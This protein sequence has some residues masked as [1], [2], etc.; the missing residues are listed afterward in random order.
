MIA[1]CGFLENDLRQFSREEGVTL[2]DSMETLGVDLR[3]RVKWFGAKENA[4]EDVQSEILAH[5]E[6][7]SLPKELHESGGQEVATCGYDA[8]KG[9]GNPSSGDVSHGEVKIEETGG[10]CCWHKED[11]LPVSVHGSVRHWSRGGAF[12]CNHSVLGRRSWDWKMAAR[13]KRSVDVTNSRSSD[14]E[15]GER[16]CRSGD[17]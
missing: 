3:T 5:Q 8:S 16:T 17:V 6:E 10:S 15:T 4:E 9:L 13:T 11:D 12:H 2:A 14:V 1:S 7:Q